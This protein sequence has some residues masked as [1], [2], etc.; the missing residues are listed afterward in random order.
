LLNLS[1]LGESQSP[2]TVI[3]GKTAE[4]NTYQTIYELSEL[5]GVELRA[6][7]PPDRQMPRDA[8]GE[9]Q[10]EAEQSAGK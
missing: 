7:C 8:A 6:P 2:T 5:T 1:R 10:R 9:Q 4:R 3:P